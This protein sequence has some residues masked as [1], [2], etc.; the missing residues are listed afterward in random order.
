MTCEA[1]LGVQPWL[2]TAR[3]YMQGLDPFRKAFSPQSGTHWH[4]CPPERDTRAMLDKDRVCFSS[5]AP[6]A[7]LNLFKLVC[8]EEQLSMLPTKQPVLCWPHVQKTKLSSFLHQR[9]AE[10]I[11]SLIGNL[12]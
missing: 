9:K 2:P 11:L 5:W 6:T 3:G 4:V 1:E 10:E 8:R 12:Y 7:H